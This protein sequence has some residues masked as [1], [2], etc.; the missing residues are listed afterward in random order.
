MQLLTNLP[1]G[2]LAVRRQSQFTAPKCYYKILIIRLI[3]RYRPA[4]F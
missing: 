3:N 2:L 1:I 4:H